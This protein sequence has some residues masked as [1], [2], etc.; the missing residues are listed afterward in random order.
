MVTEL[1]AALARLRFQC[2]LQTPTQGQT[3]VC[4]SGEMKSLAEALTRALLATVRVLLPMKLNT[5]N[6]RHRAKESAP[7][8]NPGPWSMVGS[9]P[10]AQGRQLEGSWALVP[11]QLLALLVAWISPTPSHASSG[12]RNTNLFKLSGAGKARPPCWVA[13]AQ[14]PEPPEMWAMASVLLFFNSF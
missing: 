4:I 5:G 7:S 11:V 3:S 12:S 8:Q 13:P 9:L 6:A 14:T 2:Q 1:P 10:K